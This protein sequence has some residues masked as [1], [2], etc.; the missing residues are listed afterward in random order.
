MEAICAK[1][2]VSAKTPQIDL[3]TSYSSVL[4]YF[5][6]QVLHVRLHFHLQFYP[7]VRIALELRVRR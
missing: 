3:M 4:P 2:P 5:G 6:N 7:H 1:T